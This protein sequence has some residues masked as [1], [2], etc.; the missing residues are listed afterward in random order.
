VDL[1]EYEAE[2]EKL[3]R[4]VDV[5]EITNYIDALR[6]GLE[7]VQELPLSLRLVREIHKR[8]M[9]GVR[10]GEAAKMP[11]EFRRSQNWIG[12]PSP[13]TARFVPPP[14]EEI[15]RALQHHSSGSTGLPLSSRPRKASRS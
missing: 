5:R 10:G 1:L 3:D 13:E 9:T 15:Q 2:M 14:V 12:R 4:R 6:Y 8:L 11:G 7:G